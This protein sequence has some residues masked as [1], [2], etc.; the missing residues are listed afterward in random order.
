MHAKSVAGV[1]SAT[2]CDTLR[3]DAL[4]LGM[5]RGLVLTSE[6][7]QPHKHRTN[8][9]VTLPRTQEWE[10]LYQRIFDKTA[11][12]ND[13]YWRFAISDME[14]IRVLR[15]RPMQFYGWHFDA[16]QG[17]PR[18]ITCVINLT[19]PNTH[20]PGRFQIKGGHISRSVRKL[21]GSAT[22]WPSYIFHRAVAP[23]WGER[24]ALVTWCTGAPWRRMISI[25]KSSEIS[26]DYSI[27][28]MRVS[29]EIPCED[30]LQ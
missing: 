17:S 20:W 10:W 24:W 7:R 1:L 14:K 9:E 18:K 12:V 30:S 16:Y 27:E 8:D 5:S 22:W 26:M 28:N 6:G 3:Q 29:T 21:Q 4:A 23:W 25:A 15:Y 11:E 19:N 13:A 2:E